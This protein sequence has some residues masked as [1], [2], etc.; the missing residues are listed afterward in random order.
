[1]LGLVFSYIAFKIVIPVGRWGFYLFKYIALFGFYVH[2]FSV[3][4]GFILSGFG[5]FSELGDRLKWL[6]DEL[7]GRGGREGR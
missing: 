6:S 4:I 2:F 5:L 1:V 7:D 3:G